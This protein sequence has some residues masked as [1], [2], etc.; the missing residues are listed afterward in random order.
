MIIRIMIETDVVKCH[1]LDNCALWT[2]LHPSSSPL[3]CLPR[4]WMQM[5]GFMG[6]THRFPKSLQNELYRL[7]VCVAVFGLCTGMM[8]MAQIQSDMW[9]DL[10]N[11]ERNILALRQHVAE[12]VGVEIFARDPLHDRGF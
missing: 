4:N 8:I 10:Y 12:P 11:R 6:W 5:R 1:H 7:L 2:D 3:L 9:L